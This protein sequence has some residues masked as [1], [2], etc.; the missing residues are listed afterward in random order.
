MVF[1]FEGEMGRAG[2]LN[3]MNSTVF[4]FA[5]LRVRIGSLGEQEL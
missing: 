5:P 3:R 1:R 2:I 4:G